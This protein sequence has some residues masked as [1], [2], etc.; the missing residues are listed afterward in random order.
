[1]EPILQASESEDAHKLPFSGSACVEV[2]KY[3]HWQAQDYDICKC[4]YYRKHDERCIVV[5]AMR[6]RVSHRIPKSGHWNALDDGAKY[7]RQ[8]K[9]DQEDGNGA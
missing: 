7:L 8:R 2:P 3:R 5:E 4:I 9:D 6:I 1:M